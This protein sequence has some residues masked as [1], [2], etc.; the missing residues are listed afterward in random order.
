MLDFKVMHYFRDTLFMTVGE[1]MTVLISR[2][3]DYCRFLGLRSK[4]F[5]YARTK[6]QEIIVKDSPIIRGD[7]SSSL[8]VLFIQYYKYYFS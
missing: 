4:W 8:K 7:F 2:S 1:E 5:Y 3:V 6:A